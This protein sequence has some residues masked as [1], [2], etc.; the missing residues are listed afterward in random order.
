MKTIILRWQEFDHHFSIEI[1]KKTEMFDTAQRTAKWK[2][3]P[4]SV[5]KAQVK[6]RFFLQPLH[7]ALHT[8]PGKKK[9]NN[10]TN[11]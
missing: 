9:K 11:P 8:S 1:G 7:Y 5:Q 4:G 6:A 2:M 3:H 10:Q